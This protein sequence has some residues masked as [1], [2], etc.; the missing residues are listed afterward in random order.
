MTERP[1]DVLPEEADGTAATDGTDGLGE[2]ELAAARR[3]A[4]RDGFAVGLATAVYGISFGALA[5]AAGLDVWQTCFLSLVM[6]TGGSQFALVGVLASGGVAAGGSAIAT[7]AMLGIRNVIYGMRMK[8][9]V[10]PPDAD[11]RPASVWRRVAAAWITIDESTA[12]AL[13]QSDDRAA[14]TGF[15]VT[16][17]VIFIG[18]NLTTLAGALIG[19][20]IG[21]TRAWGLD[22]AAAAAFLGLLWPRLKRFQAGAVAVGAAVV[23]TLTTPVLMPGLPV[24]VAAVVAVVVGWFDLFSRR[25]AA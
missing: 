13:A 19:D 4:R 7:A 23:A 6:F 11:G 25:R 2:E 17:V 8:P 15:W 12:V 18:W 20:A 3:A 22:A 5:V 14:R 21:D 16:G 9:L 1:D 24:L 10:T